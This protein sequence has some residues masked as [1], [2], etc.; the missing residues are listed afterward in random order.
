MGCEE[1]RTERGGRSEGLLALCMHI[2]APP[3]AARKGSSL[4]SP[5]WAPWGGVSGVWAVG[6]T[7]EMSLE[8]VACTSGGLCRSYSLSSP[9]TPRV[10]RGCFSKGSPRL[11]L[12]RRVGRGLGEPLTGC[13]VIPL[14]TM[15]REFRKWMKWYGKKHAEYTVSAIA[16]CPCG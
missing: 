8:C 6:A 15:D 2:W 14:Q 16:P 5:S 12:G 1:G 4:V 10:I 7:P 9:A 11:S 13:R 3:C